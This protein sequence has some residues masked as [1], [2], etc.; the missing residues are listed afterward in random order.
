MHTGRTHTRTQERSL[1]LVHIHTHTLSLFSHS[2]STCTQEKYKETCTHIRI[3]IYI[4]NV[5]RQPHTL[6]LLELLNSEIHT[7]THTHTHSHSITHSRTYAH[8]TSP[9]PTHSK[10][11]LASLLE[12]D[13]ANVQLAKCTLIHS[14][15]RARG[16]NDCGRSQQAIACLSMRTLF[17]EERVHAQGLM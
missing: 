17:S 1:S 12:N 13:R 8:T 6:A 10:T 4:L 3:P 16:Y 14:R 5:K 2:T 11:N 15:A 7:H 9:M